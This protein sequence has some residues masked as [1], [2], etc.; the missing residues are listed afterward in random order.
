MTHQWRNTS[1]FLIFSFLLCA[2][3]IASAQEVQNVS[4]WP[5]GVTYEIFVQSFADSNG[6][7]IGDIN[8]M[9]AKLDYLKSLGIGGIWVMPMN[10]SPSEHKYDVLNYYDI[11]PHYGTLDDFKRFVAE[12]HKRNIKV[13]MDMVFNH[14]SNRNPWFIDAKSNVNSP[15]RDYYV[16]TNDDDPQ[17]QAAGNITAGESVRRNH[18]IKAE[19]TH[20]MYYAQFGRNMPDL[21]YD[22]PKLRE[23]AFKIGKFWLSEVN[24]DG[25]RLD[26][27]RHIFPDNRPEDNHAWW[28]YFH[29]EMQK[30]KKDVYLVGE[31]WA[32][33]NVVGPYLKGLTSSFN[34]DMAGEIIKAINNST[35]DTLAIHH[36]NIEDYYKKINPE[37]IDATFLTNH[38]QVR[39]LSVLD[40]NIDKA[41]MAAALL[42]TLPG[43]PYIY[44]GEEIGMLGKKPDPNI[45]EP[46]LWDKKSVDKV[47]TTWE[48]AKFSTDST[49]IPAAV[50]LKNKNSIL[51]YYKKL[52]QLRNSSKALT[53][54]EIIPQNLGSKAIC[55]FIRYSGS[56]SLLVI[57]NL[58]ADKI[59]MGL[60][61]AL[62]GYVKVLYA[63]K[64]IAYK[65]TLLTIQP[66]TTVILKK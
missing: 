19:G 43:S 9:T 45:R 5:H 38:D 29:K 40:N 7:G 55:S 33:A 64:T 12:A 42:F 52:I 35:G 53:F 8:G 11:D 47:S 57:N 26:A 66:Y 13:I 37:Y 32:P 50:Q 62:A 30:V 49:V 14:S 2:G 10:P 15:Y 41:K 56:D 51:Q 63:S 6:D 27:A 22:S 31:V 25:F 34:F 1:T 44:Y 17:V 59:E 65:Q 23:E 60:T 39:L 28:V 36:K 18:W 24:V 16:W 20:F 58:S 61:S 48:T 3:R 21:N 46:F 54:G 4:I